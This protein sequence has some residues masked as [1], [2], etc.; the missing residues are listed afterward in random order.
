M[1]I[2]RLEV[3]AISRAAGQSAV[4][5]AAY[6]TRGNLVDERTGERYDYRRRGG[7]GPTGIVLA[8]GPADISSSVLWNAAETAE[9]RK[10]ST[11]AREIIL[12]LPHEMDGAGHERLVRSMLGELARRHGLAGEYAIHAPNDHPEADQRNHH[13]HVMLTTRRVDRDEAGQLHF[14]KK[15]RELDDQKT[16]PVEITAWREIWEHA[17]NRELQLIGA[18]LV[19]AKSLAAQGIDRRPQERQGVRRTAMLRKAQPIWRRQQAAATAVGIERSTVRGARLLRTLRHDRQERHQAL[20]AAESARMA[21]QGT[22]AAPLPSPAGE[23]QAPTAPPRPS[24][25]PRAAQK[26]LGAIVSGADLNREIPNAAERAQAILWL[27]MGRLGDNAQR[28][29][30]WAHNRSSADAGVLHQWWSRLSEKVRDQAVAWA[31]KQ[32]TAPAPAP[33]PSRGEGR[34]QDLSSPPARPDKRTVPGR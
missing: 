5:K 24:P 17:V 21:L 22:T 27:A 23:P 18:P 9:N 4:A 7:I 3:K 14:G 10:N 31:Q 20:R 8:D 19:S 28:T 34:A 6:R 26:P 30:R 32:A 11:V 33:A 29:W 15:T 25:P 2:Y 12:A 16:G 13:A 1:S